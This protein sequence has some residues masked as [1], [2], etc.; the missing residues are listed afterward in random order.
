VKTAQG[1]AV[2]FGI[3]LIGVMYAATAAAGLKTRAQRDALR[4]SIGL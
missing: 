3:A 4:R 2:A 1:I